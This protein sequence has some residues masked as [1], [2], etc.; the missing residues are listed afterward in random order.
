MTI[1]NAMHNEQRKHL[2]SCYLK[3]GPRTHTQMPRKT[4]TCPPRVVLDD[5]GVTGLEPA[6]RGCSKHQVWRVA[7]G[8]GTLLWLAGRRHEM[9]SRVEMVDRLQQCARRNASDPRDAV[10]R[11]PGQRCA[12]EQTRRALEQTRRALEQTRRALEQTGRALEQTGLKH[13]MPSAQ[14]RPK[15]F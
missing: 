10:S 11:R 13:A 2:H 7:S 1:R 15:R 8:V 14:T 3:T 9:I 5:L 12:L 4:W 6:T